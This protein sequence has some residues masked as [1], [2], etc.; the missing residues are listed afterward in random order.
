MANLSI[1][2][3]GNLELLITGPVAVAV[4][5]WQG[6]KVALVLGNNDH[7]TGYASSKPVPESN[8]PDSDPTGPPSVTLCIPQELRISVLYSLLA[9]ILHGILTLVVLARYC[10]LYYCWIATLT[11][12]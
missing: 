8:V 11:C 7:V 5:A 3:T 12:C 9:L 10:L 4:A 2:M 1:A 6:V